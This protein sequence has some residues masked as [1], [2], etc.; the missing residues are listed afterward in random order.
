MI[1]RVF[2]F[3]VLMSM[4][5]I[6]ASSIEGAAHTNENHGKLTKSQFLVSNSME[7]G[8]HR[9]LLIYP[10]PYFPCNIAQTCCGVSPT[11]PLLTFCFYLAIDP[12]NCG[13]CG[14]ICPLSTPDCCF[15][16]CVNTLTDCANC[17]FCS[18]PCINS[19]CTHGLCGYAR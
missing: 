1:T 11:Q 15:R 6:V 7:G 8:S 5:S 9:K 18:N 17:G 19:S 4:Q 2:V 3:V 10:C 12:L 14:N 16:K 13:T